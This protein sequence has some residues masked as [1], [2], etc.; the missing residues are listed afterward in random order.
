MKKISVL[1]RLNKLGK[2]KESGS[3][4]T[5]PTWYDSEKGYSSQSQLSGLSL[6]AVLLWLPKI[7]GNALASQKSHKQNS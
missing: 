4:F 6:A 2:C 7:I 3:L 1:G 5:P